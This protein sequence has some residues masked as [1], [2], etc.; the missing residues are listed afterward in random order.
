MNRPP[1]ARAALL[2]ALLA[3][4]AALAACGKMGPLERPGPLFGHARPTAAADRA[5]AT[6]DPSQPVETVDPRDEGR[7]SPGP[8]RSDPIPGQGPDPV[9]VAPPTAFPSPYARPG[10]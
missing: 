6:Q 2:A 1:L 8:S 7:M 9:G 3:S 5:G 10:Q 4:A